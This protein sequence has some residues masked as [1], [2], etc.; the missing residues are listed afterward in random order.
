MLFKSLIMSN[1]K[2]KN[3]NSKFQTNTNSKYSGVAE[4]WAIEDSLAGYNRDLVKKL[5]GFFDNRRNILEFGA[6]IGTLARLWQKETGTIPECLEIDPN[7]SQ[8]IR[9]RGLVCYDNLDEINSKYDGIYTSNVLEHIENE[10]IVLRQLHG[11]L[12]YGGIIAIYVP[13]FMCLY[14]SMDLAVGHYR[15]YRAKELCKLLET[16]GFKVIHHSY[17]DGVGFFIWLFLKLRGSKGGE[18]LSNHKALAA[19]D[20]FIYPVSSFLDRLGIKYLFGKNI[21]VIA[22]KIDS[23]CEF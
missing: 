21:M 3:S 2:I 6:G 20:K 11:Q 4:L 7:L 9:D 12:K 18:G 14:S 19:Y 1:S 13:A 8:V 5:S 10:S 16:S 23:D 15:R 17:A 22:K